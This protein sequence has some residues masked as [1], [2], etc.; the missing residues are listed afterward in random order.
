[1]PY[2]VLQ[3][4]MG[5]ENFRRKVNEF[6][7]HAIDKGITVEFAEAVKNQVQQDILAGRPPIDKRFDALCKRFSRARRHIPPD[8]LN[9]RRELVGDLRGLLAKTC[10]NALKPG[11]IIMDEF[12]RFKDLFREESETGELAQKLLDHKGVS[13]LLLSATPYK[14]YTTPEELESDD[15]QK[16]FRQTLEILFGRDDPRLAQL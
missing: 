15:H 7:K 8:D 2:N 10:L 6:P 1:S 4:D 5:T 12:Q 9:D 13:T 11:L 14:M 3:G 16:D